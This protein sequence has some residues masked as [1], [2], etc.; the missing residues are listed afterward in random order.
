MYAVEEGL[1]PRAAQHWLEEGFL[2][3]RQ[4]S[5]IA[6]LVGDCNCSSLMRLLADERALAFKSHA[7]L[8]AR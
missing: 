6:D 4:A 8:H 5:L 3:C 2:V 7:L 1:A